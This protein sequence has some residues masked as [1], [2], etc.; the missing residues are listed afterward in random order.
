METIPL[1]KLK[2]G[3]GGRKRK[4]W[5]TETVAQ[6]HA[7]MAKGQEA[8]VVRGI[9]SHALR[10]QVLHHLQTTGLKVK[11]HIIEEPTNACYVWFETVEREDGAGE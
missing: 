2:K 9:N 6:C 11:A 8:L 10:T 7:L 4:T 5:V 1:S 3:T